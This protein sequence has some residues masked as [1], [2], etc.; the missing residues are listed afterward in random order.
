MIQTP[1]YV[2]LLLLGDASLTDYTQEAELLDKQ[3]IPVLNVVATPVAALAASWLKINAPHATLITTWDKHMMFWECLI[4][5]W[6]LKVGGDDAGILQRMVT[7]FARNPYFMVK[8]SVKKFEYAFSTIQRAITKLEKLEIVA[9]VS[10][11]KRDRVYCATAILAIL[12]EP[13]KL[14]VG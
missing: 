1:S 4:I 12:E 14:H 10:K 6:K 3:N 9:Q 2:A 7:H 5:K 8:A 13:T 11:G